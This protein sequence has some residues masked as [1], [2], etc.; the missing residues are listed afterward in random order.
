[1]VC[2]F[3]GKIL[4]GDLAGMGTCGGASYSILGIRRE[5]Q[6]RG[7]FITVILG[8]NRCELRPMVDR[9]LIFAFLLMSMPLIGS[10]WSGRTKGCKLPHSSLHK[11]HHLSTLARFSLF[12]KRGQKF[13]SNLLVKKIFIYKKIGVK[14]IQSLKGHPKSSSLPFDLA[15]NGKGVA[16]LVLKHTYLPRSE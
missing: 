4:F 13:S 9:Y 2:L 1:M 6:I 11:V 8:Q 7:Q 10:E 15:N 14:R 5:I 3:V 12:L 16:L